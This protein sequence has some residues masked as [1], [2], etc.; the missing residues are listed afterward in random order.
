[1]GVRGHGGRWLLKQLLRDAVQ[2]EVQIAVLV[3]L[4]LA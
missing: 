1:M 4:C 2:A 3:C